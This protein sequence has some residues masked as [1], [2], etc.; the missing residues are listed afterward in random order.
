[1][2]RIPVLLLGFML[3]GAAV[4]QSANLVDP[5]RPPVAAGPE[6]KR[7]A[8]ASA[9]PQL[10]SVLISPAR[11]VAV[12]SGKTVVQGGKYGDATVTAITEGA[13]QLQYA[14]RRQTLRLMPGIVKRDRRA[15]AGTHSDKGN[16][17]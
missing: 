15:G 7:E 13:V 9:G 3:S 17:R 16:S 4:S 11:R 10:Q 2:R 6:A 1:M 14:D 5:T 12:I 8:V